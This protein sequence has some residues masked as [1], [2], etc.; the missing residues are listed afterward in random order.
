MIKKIIRVLQVASAFIGTIVGAGFA[1]GKEIVQFFT[2]YQDNGTLGAA[3][4]GIVITLAGTKMMIYAR[5]IGAYS[6]NELVIH[7]FGD[8]LGTA[9]QALIFFVILGITGVMLAGAGAVFQEQLGWHRQIGIV[10]ALAVGFL[11]LS[12]GIRGLLLINTL[13]VPMLAAFVLAVFLGRGM[14]PNA[15]WL[16]GNIRWVPAA[17]S[18]AS[19]NILTALVVLVPLAK[20]TEDESVLWF[21]GILGGAGLGLI[22]ILI[23]FLLLGSPE[24]HGFEMPMAEIVRHFGPLIHAGFA[25]VVFGEIL[26]TFIGNIFGLARQLRS[27]FPL[28]SNIRTAMLILFAGA[29]LISQAGYGSLIRTLYPFFGILCVAIILYM[30]WIRLPKKGGGGR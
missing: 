9:I 7:I 13:V 22:L 12:K 19:F 4:S 18:Y 16:P 28:I 3:L 8:R 2:Q 1:S 15:V 29:F 14:V 30:L 27:T 11:F 17:V 26:T 6:F 25:A 21:G 10:L 20:E 23:H 24:S 5:R